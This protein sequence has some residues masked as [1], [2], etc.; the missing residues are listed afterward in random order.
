MHAF[1][2]T[3]RIRDHLGVLRF[4]ADAKMLIGH[5]RFATHGDA[6]FNINNHPHP[7]DGGWIVHNGV[8]RNYRELVEQLELHPVSHCDSEVL[9]LLMETSDGRRM[10]R[11]L[12]AASLAKTGPMAI[13]ALW[14]ER[15]FALRS[16]NPL[17]LAETK[18]AFYLGS[19]AGGL[20]KPFSLR[21]DT[22][23]EFHARDGRMVMEAHDVADEM[24]CLA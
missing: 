4:A 7:C 13:L 8:V 24:A 11:L 14:R 18:E 9:G 5:C 23:L 15:M 22:L 20:P 21:D 6:K 10:D 2:Q 19:L 12:E 3:G 16:G 17:H 1:K